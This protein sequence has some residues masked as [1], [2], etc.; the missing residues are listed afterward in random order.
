MKSTLFVLITMM[1]MGCGAGSSGGGGAVA[2]LDGF[3][4]E[5]VG[6]GITKAFKTNTQGELSESGFLSNG[7][8]SGVWMTYFSGKEAGRVKTMAAY[9]DGILNGPYY[10]MSNRGQIESEANYQN[11]QYHGKVLTYKFGRPQTDKM[12]KNGKLDGLSTDYYSDGVV[13][14]EIYFKNGKQDG[15]MKW[16]NEEGELTMEYIYKNGEKV[17]GGIVEKT[18]TI[19]EEK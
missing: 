10:T 18:T 14:K 7:K 19:I 17:S 12:Y 11:N 6:N 16:Y 13:Q 3:Q 1:L 9:T 8:K 5:N 2:D 15:T 4:T